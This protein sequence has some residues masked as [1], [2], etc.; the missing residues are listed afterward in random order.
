MGKIK[1][2][3]IPVGNSWI[4]VENKNDF[5]SENNASILLMNTTDESPSVPNYQSSN[6]SYLKNELVLNGIPLTTSFFIPSD[7]H[8][9]SLYFYTIDIINNPNPEDE[10]NP[11]FNLDRGNQPTDPTNKS[12]TLNGNRLASSQ[13]DN[14]YYWKM[15]LHN[16]SSVP[17]ENV[18]FYGIPLAKGEEDE[19]IFKMAE[20]EFNEVEELIDIMI[21]GQPL[22][23]GRIGD[24]YYL[25]VKF[26]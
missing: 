14:R 7:A 22:T 9:T 17:T 19:L 12:F 10:D 16:T 23:V 5:A 2:N 1:I 13:I 4:A 20:Y 21:G 26:V 11:S 15:K 8:P 18:I 25:I 3:T 24:Q 6:L